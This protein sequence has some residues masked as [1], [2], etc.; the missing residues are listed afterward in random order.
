MQEWGRALETLSSKVGSIPKKFGNLWS[1]SWDK[2]IIF[3]YR[4]SLKTIITV[5][6]GNRRLRW[7]GQ[8][9]RMEEGTSAFKILS[10]KPTGKR[11]LGSPRPR[12]EEN[13]RMDLKEISTNA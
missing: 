12:C 10:D 9:A 2:I 5:F 6:S 13:I 4:T 1:R 8:V 11:L 3:F 7:A